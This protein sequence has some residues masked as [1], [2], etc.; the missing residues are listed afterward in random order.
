M[1]EFSDY[2]QDHILT[3]AKHRNLI[4]ATKCYIITNVYFFLASQ[5]GLKHFTECRLGM[6]GSSENVLFLHKHCCNSARQV[7][8]PLCPLGHISCFMK[9]L[10]SSLHI[11]VLRVNTQLQ[12]AISPISIQ[13]VKSQASKKVLHI[14]INLPITTATNNDALI[15]SLVAEGISSVH[16]QCRKLFLE[17]R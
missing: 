12:E 10:Y 8:A 17:H 13:R 7:C 6:V 14:N 4:Q 16:L 5:S 2:L 1:I 9:L 3:T 15:M 11:A